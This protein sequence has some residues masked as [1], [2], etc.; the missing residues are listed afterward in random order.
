MWNLPILFRFSKHFELLAHSMIFSQKRFQLCSI[1]MKRE[2][3]EILWNAAFKSNRKWRNKWK[4][5]YFDSANFCRAV[6]W[7]RALSSRRIQL[8]FIDWCRLLLNRLLGNGMLMSPCFRKR[9]SPFAD[10]HIFTNIVQI[11]HDYRIVFISHIHFHPSLQIF[12]T[13]PIAN[14]WKLS[15]EIIC[16]HFDFQFILIQYGFPIPFSRFSF[17]DLNFRIFL[18]R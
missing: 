11:V 14:M 15:L 10:H 12:Y 8:M 7:C 4:I 9:I 16:F 18:E 5:S 17:P 2:C 1:F 6:F 3:E 13:L